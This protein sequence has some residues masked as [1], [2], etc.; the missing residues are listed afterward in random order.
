MFNVAKDTSTLI[1]GCQAVDNIKR[2]VSYNFEVSLTLLMA[3]SS[4]HFTVFGRD[5]GCLEVANFFDFAWYKICL[6]TATR[7]FAAGMPCVLPTDSINLQEDVLAQAIIN[8]QNNYMFNFYSTVDRNMGY[9]KT[10]PRGKI[11][12]KFFEDSIFVWYDEIFNSTTIYSYDKGV[13]II[14]NTNLYL[15]A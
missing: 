2:C 4:G 15:H 13:P 12:C 7:P 3:I 6:G 5:N 9:N 10:L 11:T 8:W 1:Y 14:I